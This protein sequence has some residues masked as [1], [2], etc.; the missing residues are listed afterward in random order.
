MLCQKKQRMIFKG[1]FR[2]IRHGM[3]FFIGYKPQ[4]NHIECRAL[5]TSLHSTLSN[6]CMMYCIVEDE[7]WNIKYMS[8]TNGGEFDRNIIGYDFDLTPFEE[9]RECHYLHMQSSYYC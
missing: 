2:E 6:I 8:D 9:K 3:V 1:I 5:P 4:V 7:R